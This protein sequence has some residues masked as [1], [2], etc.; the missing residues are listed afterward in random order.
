MKDLI[1]LLT[2]SLL[3]DKE[4]VSL[5]PI[6][7]MEILSPS[8]IYGITNNGEKIDFELD[9]YLTL[10]VIDENLKTLIVKDKRIKALY[11]SDNN[12]TSLDVSK[13][14]NLEDLILSKTFNQG[15]KEAIQSSGR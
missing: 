13:C 2:N 15:W 4:I 3:K 12:L 1:N 7:E 10:K 6:N 11:C 5:T 8:S 14:I 9:E